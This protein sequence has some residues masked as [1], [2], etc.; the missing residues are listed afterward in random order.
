MTA[1]Q[2]FFPGR[3]DIDH[4]HSVSKPTLRPVA[5]IV[6]AALLLLG[7]LCQAQ[8]GEPVVTEGM[9]TVYVMTS[10]GFRDAYNALA[11]QF[12]M[13][14]GVHL[15]AAYGSSS[16]TAPNAIPS[17]LQRGE[18]AD[19]IIL[20]QPSLYD[21]TEQ[22][23]VVSESR[24]D[25]A[26][27]ILGVIVRSGAEKPDISDTEAFTSMLLKAD[28]IGYSTSM[29]G[30][31]LAAEL[32]PRL[33]IAEQLEPKSGPVDNVGDSVARGEIEIGIQ[34]V[35]ALLGFDGV[36]YVGPLPDELQNPS[37]FSAGL[38]S[39]AGNPQDAMLLL[40]FLS[41]EQAAQVIAAAVPGLRPAAWRGSAR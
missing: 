26:D 13:A 6:V 19:V 11:A 38:T 41:S 22:G 9:R 14:S 28:S 40:E 10:G 7:P 8:T 23:Y 35:S 4:N 3:N 24:R 2:K 1:H 18:P 30:V 34:Q 17:R 27:S 15:E 37:T 32:F 39:R 36:D 5:P 12:E 16:G 33:G 21:L 29:S 31:Y 20:S 25:L